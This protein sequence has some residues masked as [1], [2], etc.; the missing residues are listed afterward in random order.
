M[1]QESAGIR[2]QRLIECG[3]VDELTLSFLTKLDPGPIADQHQ[4][5]VCQ[6]GANFDLIGRLQA[7]RHVSLFKTMIS[8]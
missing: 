7:K 6:A 2:F 4:F 5:V 1:S 3:Y 8:I